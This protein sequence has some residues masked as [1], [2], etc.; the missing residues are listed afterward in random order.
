[1]TDINVLIDARTNVYDMDEV[2]QA[3]I[4]E[5]EY[6]VESART[7]SYCLLGSVSYHHPELSQGGGRRDQVAILCGEKGSGDQPV[8]IYVQP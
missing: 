8:N 2:T 6:Q 3:D 4:T 7:S 5:Q 1:M